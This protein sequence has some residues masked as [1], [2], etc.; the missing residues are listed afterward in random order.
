M[1]DVT[2]VGMEREPNTT[3]TPFPW[4]EVIMKRSDK[5]G[6]VKG[7]AFLLAMLVVVAVMLRSERSVS[8]ADIE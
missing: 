7:I 6:K 1:T 4:G 2:F 5:A 8:S 3:I